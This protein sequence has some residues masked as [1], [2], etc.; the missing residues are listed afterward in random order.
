[1][2]LQQKPADPA[3]VY[4]LAATIGIDLPDACVAGVAA[5]LA[6]LAEHA[7]RLDGFVFPNAPDSAG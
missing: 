6:L 7:A 1:M 4:A 3:F 5:N 2:A